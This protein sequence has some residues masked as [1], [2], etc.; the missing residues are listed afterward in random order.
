MDL[1]GSARAPRERYVGQWIPEPLP[2]RTEWVGG[3]TPADPP[4]RV[5][6]DESVAVAFLVV[7]ASMP[8][9]ERV[10]FVLHDVFPSPHTHKLRPRTAD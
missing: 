3:G 5:T 1:L 10:A 6:L 7:L 8:P 2:G 9:A 4:D